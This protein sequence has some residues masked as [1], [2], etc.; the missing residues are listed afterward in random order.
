MH[1]LLDECAEANA[2]IRTWNGKWVGEARIGPQAAGE[3]G[4]SDDARRALVKKLRELADVVE[5]DA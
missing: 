1:F 3:H 4:N 2:E 5:R